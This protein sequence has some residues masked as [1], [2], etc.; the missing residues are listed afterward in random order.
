MS[1]K[2]IQH[3]IPRFLWS[4]PGPL[5]HTTANH[6]LLSSLFVWSVGWHLTMV[7]IGQCFPSL[8]AH[9]PLLA[10]GSTMG[11]HILAHVNTVC[12]NYRYPKL[13]MCF[14]ELIL[15]RYE[16]TPFF[17]NHGSTARVGQGILIVEVLRWHSDTPYSGKE[18]LWLFL[19][20]HQTSK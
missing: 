8:F 4:T 18:V 9:G 1:L 20:E 15:D 7:P 11:P 2:Y 19:T 10:S 13:K 12:P 17:F 14:L 6:H 5:F 16:Y 3:S